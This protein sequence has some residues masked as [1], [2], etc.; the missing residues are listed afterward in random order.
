MRGPSPRRFATAAVAVLAGAA[1][2]AASGPVAACELSAALASGFGACVPAGAGAGA[3][4]GALL[5]LAAAP[6]CRQGSSR[7]RPAGHRPAASTRA[8]AWLVVAA[9]AAMAWAW[10]AEWA[11]SA[12]WAGA[13]EGFDQLALLLVGL[14]AA[15]VG[16]VLLV[17]ASALLRRR[18]W[19]RWAA[20][21]GFTLAAGAALPALLAAVSVVLEPGVA[22]HPGGDVSPAELAPP[23][24]ALAVSVAVVVL[25]LLPATARD[26][27]GAG[28]PPHP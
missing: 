12:E 23:A 14:V 6:L 10:T 27:R 5:G 1:L 17:L 2:G 25:V 28:P 4:T 9:V 26:F 15:V 16:V 20:V 8:A 22:G 24:A 21:V 18:G 11:A 3:L 19:A 13:G 7:R